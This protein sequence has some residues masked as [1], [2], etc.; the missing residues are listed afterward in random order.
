M[1]TAR[2]RVA[3]TEMTLSALRGVDG[4]KTGVRNLLKIQDA[5][6]WLEGSFVKLVRESGVAS[7]RRANGS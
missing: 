2:A 4:R 5:L 3:A 1:A 6:T 7:V